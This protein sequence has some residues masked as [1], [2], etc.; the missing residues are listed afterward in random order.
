MGAVSVHAEALGEVTESTTA[1]TTQ[2]LTEEPIDTLVRLD[3]GSYVAAPAVETA[4]RRRRWLW[5]IPVVIVLLAIGAVTAFLLANQDHT[6]R[7]YINAL[8]AG[9]FDK[10]FSGTRAAINHAHEVCDGFDAGDP[11]Q[12]F[13]YEKVGVQFYCADYLDGFKVIPTPEQQA[14]A[15]YSDLEKANLASG[16]ASKDQAVKAA[17]QV[18]SGFEAGGKVQGLQADQIAVDHYCTDLKDEFKLL[19]ERIFS[20]TFTILDTDPSIYFPSISSVGGGC[21][22]DGG[23]GDVNAST[24]VVVK[25]NAG[26]VLA[27]TELGVGDGGYI[28]CKFNFSFKLTEGE[29]SYVLSVGHRGEIAY[30]WAEMQSPGAIALSLG[31]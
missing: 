26:T 22:G 31:E 24:A 29:D 1:G 18:C 4:R 27:R 6:N 25:N 16:F 11:V 28:S 17:Q 30:T 7:N 14:D 12:G 21:E 20:G 15:Y 23:Y 9:G 8:D 10:S 13:D 3:D 5:A 2:T 19:H